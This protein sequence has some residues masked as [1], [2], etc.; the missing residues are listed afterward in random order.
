MTL[1]R[2]LRKAIERG[3]FAAVEDHWLAQIEEDPLQTEYFVLA[4]RSLAGSG[5]DHR[6]RML[7]ELVD[8][9]LRKS[10]AWEVRLHLMEGA[11]ELHPAGEKPHDEIVDTLEQIYEGQPSLAGLMDLVGLRRK[12]DDLSRTWD[13][14]HRL[15]QL[16]QFELGTVV[17]MEGK[18]VG[19]IVE[20]NEQL[21]SFKVDLVGIGEIRVGFRA[22]G[23]LLTALDEDHFLRRKIET[24]DQLESLKPSE[25]LRELMAS[26][27]KPLTAGEVKQAVLGLVATKSWSSWWTSARKHRQVVAE[28]TGT[29]RTYR[30]ADTDAD[31]GEAV[32][33]QFGSATLEGKLKIFR[34]EAGRDPALG[35]KM[36]KRLIELGGTRIA[37]KPAIA[38]AVAAALEREGLDEGA[39]ALSTGQLVDGATDPSSWIPD[40]NDRTVRRTAF[41]LVRRRD[42]WANLFPRLLAR[43]TEAKL[44]DYLGEELRDGDSEALEVFLDSTIAQPR[45]Q[46]AAFV[47][48]AERIGRE[49]QDLLES[50]NPLRLLQSITSV[51]ERPEFSAFKTRLKQLIAD[52]NCLATLIARVEED[53]A[54][55]ALEALRRAHLEEYQREQLT[56]GVELRFPNVREEQA[57]GLYALTSSIDARRAE[58]KELL[59]VEIPANRKAIEEARELGDLRE[60]FEYKSARQRH[61]YLSA[62]VAEIDGELRRVQPID[63]SIVDDAEVR[64]GSRVVFQDDVKVISIL[65]PWESKPEEDIISYES[66]LA[67]KILGRAPGDAVDVQGEELVIDR[68]EAAETPD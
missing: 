6:A 52:S 56:T 33:Q 60:N 61:E 63:L 38:F 50:K 28:G 46:P 32:L 37:S 13:K 25:Q 7:L 59:E 27:N 26:Y 24:P 43:E 58:L 8:D 65:G 36:A 15:E 49:G 34:K 42:D 66:E 2:N 35:S 20:V 45:R 23:K 22:A 68:I 48:A 18:G 31:A 55:A 51:G 57:V 29:K 39:E 19:R 14:V 1:P 10:K 54:E 12:G 47:W 17:A 62:R 4:A 16:M 30:W 21:S 67:G 5:E 11:R 3:D 9:Q 53:Q 44:L 64:V 40:I 41:E